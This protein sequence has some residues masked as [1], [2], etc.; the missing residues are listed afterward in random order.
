[1]LRLW[2][3]AAGRKVRDL[4]DGATTVVALTPDGPTALLAAEDGAL[5]F[6][7]LTAVRRQK[8][9]GPPR[10]VL[11][12]AL[13]REGRWGVVAAA[14]GSLRRVAFGAARAEAQELC[15]QGAEQACCLALAPAGDLLL[16]GETS[17]TVKV[18]DRRGEVLAELVGHR[19]R[20][21]GVDVSPDG[22]LAV[23]GSYDQTVRL[24]RLPR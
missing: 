23:S 6:L 13:A 5:R 11:C 22:R 10:R 7:N 18:Y 8:L 3:L 20:V 21:T 2:D 24:W 15:P 9:D 12:G 19:G 17:G 14:D 4:G 1:V 16:A